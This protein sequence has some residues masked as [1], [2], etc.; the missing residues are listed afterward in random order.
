MYLL[1][2][3]LAAVD[4]H[5]ARHLFDRCIM[6]ILREKSRV[7]CTHHVHYLQDADMVVL[8][9]NGTIQ[10][11]G[12]HSVLFIQSQVSIVENINE[13]GSNKKCMTSQT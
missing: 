7:L 2:D 11:A 3:P 5:V 10:K 4:A 9:E 12:K 6:G 1:D 8:M 13:K